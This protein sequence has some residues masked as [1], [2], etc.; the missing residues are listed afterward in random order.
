MYLPDIQTSNLTLTAQSSG[1]APRAR[2]TS[3]TIPTT[4]SSG[5][6]PG[7]RTFSNPTPHPNQVEMSPEPENMAIDT[8]ED[9]PD[10]IYIPEELLSDVDA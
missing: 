2:T 7:T 1:D 10:L 6:A 4:Q 5:N 3:N 9:M 8:L